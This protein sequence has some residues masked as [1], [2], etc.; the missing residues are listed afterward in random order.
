MTAKNKIKQLSIFLIVAGILSFIIVGLIEFKK[1]ITENELRKIHQLFEDEKPYYYLEDAKSIANKLIPLIEKVTGKKFKKIPEIKTINTEELQKVLNREIDVKL[2]NYRPGYSRKT[3]QMMNYTF[4]GI[5]GTYDQIVYLLPN[6]IIPVCKA[7]N[8]DEK[9]GMDIVRIIIAHELT[10]AL[11]DQYLN[12]S[13]IRNKPP[14]KE[15]LDAFSATIEG[16]AVFVEKEVGRLLGIKNHIIEFFPLFDS[17]KL[18]VNH[19]QLKQTM[20]SKISPVSIY[21]LGEK[22]INYHHSEGGNKSVWNIL[23]NPP[24]DTNMIANPEMYFPKQY[25]YLNYKSMLENLYNYKNHYKNLELVYKNTSFSRLDLSLMFKNIDFPD[26]SLLISKVQHY[27]FFYVYFQDMLLAQITFVVLDDSDYTS[28]YISLREKYIQ[29]IFQNIK[30][31]I[32]KE[33]WKNVPLRRICADSIDFARQSSITLKVT[34]SNKK[35]VVRKNI[36]TIIA[37]ENMIAIHNDGSF[38]LAPCTIG[39]IASKIFAR[40][41]TAKNQDSISDCNKVE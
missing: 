19:P 38:D 5:Y 2:L 30:Q 40:Y 36:H 13:K 3:V 25:N 11:Q 28:Q 17:V 22:F 9:Y 35:K 41:Q 16:H 26:K 1:K 27:Q 29:Y 34:A 39:K 14:G 7:L 8:L 33:S 32:N 4:Y 23:S 31:S 21:T 24:I 6:R 10:H 37:K 20:E 12:L 18:N 15:E